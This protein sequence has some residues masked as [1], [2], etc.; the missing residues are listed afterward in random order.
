MKFFRLDR[1]TNAGAAD[2]ASSTDIINPESVKIH[3]VHDDQGIFRLGILRPFQP[4]IR[5]ILYMFLYLFGQI[6][7]L[8]HCNFQELLEEIMISQDHRLGPLPEPYA[9]RF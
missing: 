6:R 5:L 9:E 1:H 3:H 8:R 7:L 2:D 4:F